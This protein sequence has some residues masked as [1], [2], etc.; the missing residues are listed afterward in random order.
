MG[1][2]S[3]MLISTGGALGHRRSDLRAPTRP[4]STMEQLLLSRRV[5]R[6]RR[7]GQTRCLPDR[8]QFVR[9]ITNWVIGAAVLVVSLSACTSGEDDGGPI[10]SASTSTES[11]PPALPPD[12][13]FNMKCRLMN[14]SYEYLTSLQQAW[15]QPASSC[16]ATEA[17]DVPQDVTPMQAATYET[18]FP[19][20]S[21]EETPA[22][23][24]K[25][26]L[27]LCAEQELAEV[28]AAEREWS[29]AALQVCPDAPRV[30]MFEARARGDWWSDG[31][32]PVAE[33]AMPP[34]IYVTSDAES[35][36]RWE[37]VDAR[38]MQADHG[39]AD[40]PKVTV[41]SSDIT[42]TSYD[43]GIWMRER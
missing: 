8:I 39:Y 25:K 4:V 27:V 41:S 10:A 38:G 5:D 23:A 11:P 14:G 1:M 28:V 20:L 35:T 13:R 34:G 9:L 32:H 3:A 33:S 24:Y 12:Y 7:I 16:Y 31:R 21:H 40:R 17:A 36:C 19:A 42:F 30:T 43:C 37:R 18:V 29:A 2:L 15:L 26:V 6:R 22:G